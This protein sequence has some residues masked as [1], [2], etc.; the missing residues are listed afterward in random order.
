VDFASFVF[1]FSSRLFCFREQTMTNR[2]AIPNTSRRLQMYR[3]VK[4][5]IRNLFN[6]FNFKAYHKFPSTIASVVRTKAISGSDALS[7]QKRPTI[8][9]NANDSVNNH[10]V[11][12]FSPGVAVRAPFYFPF[13][14]FSSTRVYGV[15]QLHHR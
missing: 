3:L 7:V 14:S 12:N 9:R 5:V 11:S 2:I 6:A 15:N 13:P 1:F 8:N 10:G 4:F